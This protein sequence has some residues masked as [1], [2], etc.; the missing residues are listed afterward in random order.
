MNNDKFI[1][2]A[3]KPKERKKKKTILLDLVDLIHN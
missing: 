2:D 3:Q 1:P